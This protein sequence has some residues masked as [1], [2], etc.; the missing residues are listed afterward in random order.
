SIRPNQ[1]FA[2]SLHYSMLDEEQ[3]RQVL[4]V[5]QRD[6]L[7]PTGLR[8]LSPN[9]P[10]YAGRYAGDMRQRDGAYHQGAVWAWLIGPFITAYLRVNGKTEAAR[11]QAKQWIDG[12]LPHLQTAGLGQV[13]EIFDGD[14]PHTARGCIAQAWSVAELLRVAVEEV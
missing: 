13:S 2:V 6:L 7:T 10:R 1:I 8:S 5:V 11:K 4:T 9:D 3:A 14:A 12:F